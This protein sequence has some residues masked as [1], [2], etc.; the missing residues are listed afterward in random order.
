MSD[1]TVT[2][3]ASIQPIENR[4]LAS[5]ASLQ[6]ENPKI[7]RQNDEAFPTQENAISIFERAVRARDQLLSLT[8]PNDVINLL[9]SETKRSPDQI[10]QD[11]SRDFFKSQNDFDRHIMDF[12]NSVL[13]AND[14]LKTEETP[15]TIVS[16]YSAYCDCRHAILKNLETTKFNW[17][18]KEL[19]FLPPEVVYFKKII[20]FSVMNNRLSSLPSGLFTLSTLTKISVND[21]IISHLPPMTQDLPNLKE[22]YMM[23]NRLKEISPDITM[24]PNLQKLYIAENELTDIPEELFTLEHLV[25]LHIGGNQ[26]TRLPANIDGL[27]SLITLTA[28]GNQLTSLPPVFVNLKNLSQLY[29]NDNK[30]EVEPPEIAQ[31]ELYMLN[32]ALN[33]CTKNKHL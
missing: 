10:K 33:P 18:T 11:L 24:L 21:N 3:P 19:T 23:K 26:L 22:F 30:F 20:S 16:A 6:I 2:N 12:R 7:K 29:L 28:W 8:T 1:L 25:S 14:S 27:K 31:M 15:K 17:D 5:Q 4:N 9:V 32:I 13:A